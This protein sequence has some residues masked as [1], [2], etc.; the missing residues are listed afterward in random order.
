MRAIIV[1]DK[2]LTVAEVPPPVPGPDDIRI[3]VRATAVNRADLLQADGHYPPP[4]GASETLGL[5]CA[6]VNAETG[7][8]VMALLPGGG[9]AE[10]SAVH[11]GSVM[12]V[13]DVLS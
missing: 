7:E 3:L 10:E 13:P 2:T 9:Y 8:R 11:Q 5:E 12:R 6:G 4:P 1:H